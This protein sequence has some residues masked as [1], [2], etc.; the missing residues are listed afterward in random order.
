MQESK[1]AFSRRRFVELLGGAAASFGL[2]SMAGCGGGGG[3]TAQRRGRGR[4]AARP[5]ACPTPSR[6]AS[7]P[8]RARSTRRTSTTASRPW[9]PATSTRACTS[10]ARRTPR[11][12][13]AWPP[14]C[15]KSRTTASTYTIKLREGVKFHDG[16]EFNAEAVKTSIERQLEPNRNSD[17]PYASFVFGEEAADNGVASV[18]AVDRHH[19]EDHP[20]RGFRPVLEEPGHGACRPHR[21]AHGR[22]GGHGRGSPSPSPPAPAPT[23][24]STGRRAP[25]SPWSPTRSTG[26]RQRPQDEEPRLPHHRRGQHPHHVAAEQRVRHHLERRSLFGQPDHRRRLRAVRRRRHDHQLHGVQHRDGRVHRP[27]GAQGHRP[28]HQRRGDGD[29]PSTAT[30]PRWRTPSCPSGWPRTA[31][32]SSR[33]PTTP[34]PPRPRWPPRASRRCSAS[35][36]PPPA[37]TTR[38]AAASS[39]ASSRATWPRSAWT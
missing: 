9:C 5:A 4:R 17:M 11:C 30:T 7:R 26:T 18:E 25:R 32:T 22:R 35:P 14:T 31:R 10:T 12:R 34:R 29:R 28:G 13:P 37:P 21:V 23:S 2:V 27:G 6:T 8:T 39:P 3:E 20:A 38:R 16:T 36:T 24:S 33:P 1:T 15:P 19:G